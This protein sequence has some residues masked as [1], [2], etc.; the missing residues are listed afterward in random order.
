M[1]FKVTG[2]PTSTKTDKKK[3]PASASATGAAA[4]SSLLDQA[5]GTSEVAPTTP[6]ASSM[7]ATGI[8]VE[9][10]P[11]QP[12]VPKDPEG[13]SSYIL[14][15]LEELE[16]DIL[17]GSPT[18]AVNKLKQALATQAESYNS[19]SQAQKEIAD[20]IDLRASIEIAKIDTDA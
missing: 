15:A 1:D 8:L 16:Q 19:L 17:S 13:R 4:F 5:S 18:S 7:P 14:D 9:D 3:K 6:V 2:T 11:A 20:E 12:D 10:A